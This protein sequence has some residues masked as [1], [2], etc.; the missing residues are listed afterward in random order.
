MRTA[1]AV[2]TADQNAFARVLGKRPRLRTAK[3]STL[4]QFG[5]FVETFGPPERAKRGTATFCSGTLS[6]RMQPRA[7]LCLPGYRARRSCI[8]GPK[9]KSGLRPAQASCRSR[10]GLPIVSPA[11]RAAKTIRFSLAAGRSWSSR[12][13]RHC[14]PSGSNGNFES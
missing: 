8:H 14:G 13:T 3:S 2:N 1:T 11:S 12:S 10:I 6:E 5:L 7:S 4:D 9:S